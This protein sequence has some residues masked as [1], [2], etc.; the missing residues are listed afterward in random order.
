MKNTVSA[1]MVTLILV[2]TF[3]V[4]LKIQP[5]RATGTIYIRADGS[6][7]PPTTPINRT[8]NV[9][10]FTGN[11]YDS[12]ILERS[13]ITIDGNQHLLQGAGSGNG[14]SLSGE[15][16]VTIE[17]ISIKSFSSGIWIGWFSQN[18]IVIGNDITNNT[19]GVNLSSSSDNNI[20]RNNIADNVIGICV[21]GDRNLVRGNNVTANS[22]VG[23]W[24]DSAS[25]DNIITDNNVTTNGEYGIRLSSAMDNR[26]S[27]NNIAN[28]QCGL[29]LYLSS[30][31]N[32]I[33]EN[34]IANN[35]EGIRPLGGPSNNEICH[36]NFLDN[37]I[38]ATSYG[39]INLWDYGYPSGGNYWSDYTGVDIFSGP[40]QDELGSDGVGD[41]P[42]IIDD[43]NWDNYPLTNPWVNKTWFC[44]L[45]VWP[46]YGIDS[47]N[48]TIAV[49]GWFPN[50]T[51]VRLERDG[52]ID[53]QGANTTLE[54]SFLLSSD[55]N[56]EGRELGQWDLVVV[57]ANGS[58]LRSE[59]AFTIYDLHLSRVYPRVL[60]NSSREMVHLLGFGF[61][62][63]ISVELRGH[64]LNISAQT[65]AVSSPEMVFACFNLTDVPPGL[66]NLT[67]IWPGDSEEVYG[68]AIE[69]SELQGEVLAAFPEFQVDE[70]TTVTYD[71]SVP[72]ISDLFITL[73][74]TTLFNYGNSWLCT[75]S[76]FHAGS[77]VTNATGSHDLILHIRN[78]EPGVYTVNITAHY[79]GA[80]MLTIWKSLPELPLEKW[81]VD[82]IYCSYGSTWHQVEVPPNK[83]SLSFEAEAM[84]LW[85]HFDIYYEEYGGANRW[86]SPMGVRTSIEI[87]NPAYGTYIVEFT[88]SAMLFANGSWSLDQTRDI[89][90][91][92]E[93]TSSLE[94]FPDYL[95]VIASVSTDRGGN[96]GFVTVEIRGIWLD[97]NA[98]VVLSNPYHDDIYARD[99]YGTSDGTTLTVLFDLTD[100]AA[101]EWSLSV[102]N[103]DGQRAVAP[104]L[105]TIE[106]GVDPEVWVE[107]VGR[108]TIRAGRNQTYILR[109]GN[110]SDVDINDVLLWIDAPSQW[111]AQLDVPP[112]EIPEDSGDDRVPC[113]L[114]TKLAAGTT[115]EFPVHIS[116]P[117]ISSGEMKV[118]VLA[119]ETFPDGTSVSPDLM[120]PV[121][122]IVIRLSEGGVRSGHVGIHIGNWMVVDLVTTSPISYKVQ[123]PFDLRVK[124]REGEDGQYLGA[125]LPIGWTV[126][127]G[128]LIADAA[129]D[130]AN[131]NEIGIYD[132]APFLPGTRNCISFVLECYES[133]GLSLGWSPITTPANIYE[134]FF[135]T[136]WPESNRFWRL[137]ARSTW[138]GYMDLC[139]LGIKKIEVL[140]STTP[141]DKY[142]PTGFDFS[143]TPPEELQHFVSPNKRFYY[144]VDFWNMENA[145]APACDVYVKDQLDTNL[146][147]SSLRLEE[148]GFLNWTIGLEPCQYFNVYVDTRPEMGLIV[149]IEGNFNP[150][151]G[152]ISCT[153][154]SLDPDT[155]ETPDDPMAGFLPPITESGL[156]VGWVS[157]SVDPNLGLPNGTRIENQAFVNFDGVG[158]Y[159]PAPKDGPFVNTIATR[160]IAV[161]DVVPLKTVVGEGQQCTINVTLLNEGIFNETFNVTL[162]ASG[163]LIETQQVIALHNGTAT[164]LTFTWNITDSTKGNYTMSAT[165]G[166]LVGETSTA[167]NTLTCGWIIVTIPGDVDG[168]RDVDIFDIVHIAGDYGKPPPPLTDPNCDIDGDGDADIF[169]I[170]AACSHYG[171]SW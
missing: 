32:A 148:I 99:V 77:E 146:N 69:I 128:Q 5:V 87:P 145:T 73:R 95:P 61:S 72:D 86:V 108:E 16:W 8:G 127:R 140:F 2:S 129:L 12:I 21:R 79:S 135:H 52:C 154:H 103:A 34:N 20:S 38:H 138:Q 33:T 24:L 71:V 80:G 142:G 63:G 163:T 90:I 144:K 68:H 49:V 93:T 54:T 109:C 28:S 3:T 149:N 97:P 67:V 120:P 19:Y 46:N 31:N 171:E 169:D 125:I 14:I 7:D 159:N 101:G 55:L 45:N 100:K 160:N 64:S 35:Q 130:R 62:A 25:N 152:E 107:I 15:N 126:A 113:V 76:L 23:I 6:I 147:W 74:K 158:P 37:T 18:N 157:F 88:D 115:Q 59:D 166:P 137:L 60:S 106:E 156:E 170:V 141:E 22:H 164:T 65:V 29:F 167:D 9:Y 139:W 150:D 43:G 117:E 40:L 56:L 112:I 110:P 83:D 136:L 57:Y 13:G 85:S 122:S 91:R 143:E 102:T 116:V 36:N 30:N 26:I 94:L 10:T 58:E 132:F 1:F 51:E 50:V 48:V 78:P 70:E 133:A 124:W 111:Q 105:F 84:G 41:S 42:Y 82:T 165:A 151:T 134:K 98:S 161:T 123:G 153:F 104:H 96:A 81:V 92:A 75:M 162:F 27:A 4:A 119:A 89:L 121:G 17:N 47:Q 168:D 39:F 118:G 114:I 131:N 53:I 44:I 155:L 11:I 66:Y